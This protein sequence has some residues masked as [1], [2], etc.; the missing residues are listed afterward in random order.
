MKNRFVVNDSVMDNLF[1]DSFKKFLMD[2]YNYKEAL[3][4][5]ISETAMNLASFYGIEYIQDICDAICSCKYTVVAE[6]GLFPEYK[7]SFDEKTGDVERNISLPLN[8]DVNSPYAREYVLMATIKLVNSYHNEYIKTNG[9]IVHRCGVMTENI[10]TN[11]INGKSLEDEFEDYIHRKIVK[12]IISP[13]E[14]AEIVP[15]TSK[16]KDPL[17]AFYLFDGSLDL[18]EITRR[19]IITGDET[20]LRQ[21]FEAIFGENTYDYLKNHSNEMDTNKITDRYAEAVSQLKETSK[22][23]A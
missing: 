5:N 1:L 18:D 8:S 11:E 4:H 13:E 21:S 19:S 20:E 2:N 15:I 16:K 17:S 6:K 12:L 10:N 22:M 3:A 9:D 14:E 7:S 23:I